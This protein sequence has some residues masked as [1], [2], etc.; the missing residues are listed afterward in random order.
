MII[1]NAGPPPRLDPDRLAAL[2]RIGCQPARMSAESPTGDWDGAFA[3]AERFIDFYGGDFDAMPE[4]LRRDIQ[5]LH[6]ISHEAFACRIEIGAAGRTFLRSY[7]DAIQV[8]DIEDDAMAKVE[9]ARSA[10]ADGETDF[11]ARHRAE[12]ADLA[13][14]AQAYRELYRSKLTSKPIP[15]TASNVQTRNARTRASRAPHTAHSSRTRSAA[16]ASSDSSSPTPGPDDD[17]PLAGQDACTKPRPDAP[18]EDRIAHDP[19]VLELIA[20]VES[21]DPR[22]RLD[23]SDRQYAKTCADAGFDAYGLTRDDR[24]EVARG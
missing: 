18:F 19:R 16:T 2:C 3:E 17:P 10:E 23:L 22:T 11:A 5:E 15:P 7:G 14:A 12:A 6:H 13:D 4:A 8:L 21:G 20:L 1:T 24:A 9:T